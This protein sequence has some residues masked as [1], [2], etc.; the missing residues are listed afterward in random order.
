[1]LLISE[2]IIIPRNTYNVSVPKASSCGYI[3]HE[4]IKTITNDYMLYHLNNINDIE[5]RYIGYIKSCMACYQCL[6]NNNKCVV[7]D[8]MKD[9]YPKLEECTDLI[10]VSPLYYGTISPQFLSFFTRLYPYWISSKDIDPRTGHPN[11]YP[12]PKNVY[13][14]GTCADEF[15]NWDLFDHTVTTIY[16]ELGWNNK[17]ICHL[18]NIQNNLTIQNTLHEFI[19]QI[20]LDY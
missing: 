8:E 7:N 16:K 13:T 1:M 10:I 3:T 2:N 18:P 15:Q 17:N 11:N 5:Y 9:V 12:K 19:K 14:I 4:I 20:S 6:K